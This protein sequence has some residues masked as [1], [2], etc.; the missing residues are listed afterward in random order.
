MHGRALAPSCGRELPLV[1]R[2][3]RWAE[4]ESGLSVLLEMCRRLSPADAPAA[5]SGMRASAFAVAA[6]VFRGVPA[7]VFVKYNE[8]GEQV[9]L[10]RTSYLASIV[11]SLYL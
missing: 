8:C 5:S 11:Y 9:N 4:Q 7:D 10:T 3:A 6:L 2:C 1:H